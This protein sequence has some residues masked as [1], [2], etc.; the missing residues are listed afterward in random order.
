MADKE[1]FSLDVFTNFDEYITP[2]LGEWKVPGMALAAVKD[3]ELVFASGFGKRNLTTDAEVTPRTIFAIGS[4]SKAFTATALAMLVDEGKLSWDTP[5]REYLPSFK[6]YDTVASEHMTPRD[7]LVHNSGLPR[8]DLAWYRADKSREKLVASLRYFEPSDTPRHK[9]AGVLPSTSGLA[10]RS[11][12]RDG[13]GLL[14]RSVAH[15]PRC[16]CFRLP[17][18]TAW[19]FFKP[20]QRFDKDVARRIFVSIYHQSTV[21]TT[22]G[23]L[24]ETF[25]DEFSTA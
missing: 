16:A 23:T 7:L 18:G 13:S 6:L 5:I 21:N 9:C 20:L 22:V 12:L 24:T 4:S 25:F 15:T 14:S 17:D 1:V 8:H 19:L 11:L 3:G 2:L 10:V